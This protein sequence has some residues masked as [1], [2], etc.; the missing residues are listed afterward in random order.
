MRTPLSSAG[1]KSE[2]S[3]NRSR[4]RRSCRCNL[5]NLEASVVRVADVGEGV[6]AAARHP[7]DK[8]AI[9]AKMQ[10]E[11]IREAVVPGHDVGD[12]GA[13]PEGGRD[14]KGFDGGEAAR[15]D[16]WIRWRDAWGESRAELFEQISTGADES[17]FDSRADHDRSSI[18]AVA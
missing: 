12:E 18:A 2:F 11:A 9:V 13:A 6:D 15:V 14:A 17:A 4:E 16:V 3:A 5:V 10:F 7:G 8:L 1:K